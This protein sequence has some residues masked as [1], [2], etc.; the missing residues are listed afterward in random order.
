M[1]L[2]K[3]AEM[4]RELRVSPKTLLN[5]LGQ[6]RV[7]CVRLSPRVVRFEP[8]KVREALSAPPSAAK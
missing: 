5:W 8:D 4:A 2:L 3:T 7:P 6:G 1:G